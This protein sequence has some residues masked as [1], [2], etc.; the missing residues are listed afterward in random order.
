M[1]TYLG[2]VVVWGPALCCC[3][4]RV[5][6]PWGCEAECCGSSLAKTATPIHCTHSHSH[7]LHPHQHHE[8]L[9]GAK[10]AEQ[11]QQAPCEHSHKDCPCGKNQQV[12][13][14]LQICKGGVVTTIDHQVHGQWNF[15]GNDALSNSAGANLS[16]VLFGAH[17]KPGLSGREILRAHHRL[18]C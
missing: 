12:L 17:A 8:H 2:I 10:Q 1:A 16:S 7:P 14:A 15:V 3:S 4:T 9:D 6:F 18:Q 13:F 11:S 5:L